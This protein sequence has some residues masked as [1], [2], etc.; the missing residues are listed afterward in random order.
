M[1]YVCP[2]SGD[3]PRKTCQRNEG[4][5]SPLLSHEIMLPAISNCKA[6]LAT[7]GENLLFLQNGADRPYGCSGS[8]PCIG[9]CIFPMTSWRK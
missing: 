1:L 8:V 7:D 6:D 2:V 4:A 5:V 9:R 3:K